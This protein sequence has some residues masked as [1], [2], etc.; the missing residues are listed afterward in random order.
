M[1][2]AGLLGGGGV[3]L[4][5]ELFPSLTAVGFTIETDGEVDS[6][7]QTTDGLV[8]ICQT[9]Y[10]GYAAAYVLPSVWWKVGS[11]RW[12]IEFGAVSSTGASVSVSAAM[13][14][15]IFAG[16]AVSGQTV[17]GAFSNTMEGSQVPSVNLQGRSPGIGTTVKRISVRRVL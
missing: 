10:S 13:R 8:Y 11:Y 6:V 2:S 16:S 1:F 9:D 15:N 3:S 7:Y 14:N 12:E 5:P 4:G 17:S